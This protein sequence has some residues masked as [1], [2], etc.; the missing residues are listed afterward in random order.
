M[1]RF[2]IVMMLPRGYLWRLG[3]V[4]SDQGK[5]TAKDL[6]TPRPSLGWPQGDRRFRK[7]PDAQACLRH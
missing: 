6:D 5:T 4:A 2:L 3:P 7:P 1:W